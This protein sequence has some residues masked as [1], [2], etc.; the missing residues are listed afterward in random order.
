MDIEV[1]DSAS[2][3]AQ[4]VADILIE[5]LSNNKRLVMGLATGRTMDAVYY[6]LVNKVKSLKIN[7]KD[8]RFFALD[9]YLGLDKNHPNSYAYY[10]NFHM[11]SPLRIPK[12]HCLIFDSMAE[13]FDSACREYEKAIKDAGGI[14]IQLLGIGTNGHIALNEPGSAL[15]SRSRV[16]ALTSSTLR[17]NKSLFKESEIPLTALSMG[18]GT[19]MEAKECMLIATGESKANIIQKIVN[20]DINSHIPATALKA[21]KNF[22]L[23]LD[24]DAAKLIK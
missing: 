14:D 16:V 10:L 21:H 19:I 15:D 1:Y 11:Y 8:A 12:E 17:S 7:C 20:G 4:R 9:E 3:A 23:I 6:D 24:R 5:K 13:D 18:I 22:K 2:Q